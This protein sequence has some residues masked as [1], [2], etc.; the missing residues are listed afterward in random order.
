LLYRLDVD[1]DFVRVAGVR[2]LDFCVEEPIGLDSNSF[3]VSL[4]VSGAGSS[5]SLTPN[6]RPA[7]GRFCT[8][9]FVEPVDD[10]DED[11][12]EPFVDDDDFGLENF[13][14][15]SRED[16]LATGG[17]SFSTKMILSLTRAGVLLSTELM[18]GGS[19]FSLGGKG[20]GLS[21]GGAL[22]V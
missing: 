18:G 10:D 14:T 17:T 6:K 5:F 11:F 2:P 1:F 8:G 16:G 9:F 13:G 20:G 12:C 19:G 15:E 3:R 4:T 7:D 21:E 22:L